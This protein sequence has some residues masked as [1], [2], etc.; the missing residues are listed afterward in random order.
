MFLLFPV[1]ISPTIVEETVLELK[2]YCDIHFPVAHIFLIPGPRRQKHWD[3]YG[4]KCSLIDT[5]SSKSVTYLKQRNRT[6]KD[7]VLNYD[8][9]LK[10]Y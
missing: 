9:V 2:V 3:F 6:E 10:I 7:Y 5:A 1:S 4:F 8:V